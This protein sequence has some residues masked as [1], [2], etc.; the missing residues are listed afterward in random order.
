MNQLKHIN[1]A[2][3]EDDYRN[4]IS[5]KLVPYVNKSSAILKSKESFYIYGLK[6][7]QKVFKHVDKKTTISF[8]VKDGDYVKKN[9]ILAN[10]KGSN[11]SILKAERV[12]LNY[13]QIMSGVY[14][15][16]KQYN[17]KINNK[18]KIK[19]LHTRKTP[20]L[21]KLPISE[22]CTAAMC[23][24]HR[25]SLSTSVLFKENHLKS[26]DD[27]KTLIRNAVKKQ[28]CLAHNRS[29]RNNSAHHNSARNNSAAP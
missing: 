29:D 27:P 1:A 9:K 8:L 23:L 2:L 18:H 22:A 6:W 24:P 16:C 13:L 14:D 25:Y 7:F 19:I 26:I 15:I 17:K 28:T 5:T 12:A 10:I 3:I 21:L 20:P 11:H 4:D